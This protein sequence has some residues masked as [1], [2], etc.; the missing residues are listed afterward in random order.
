MAKVDLL[1]DKFSE[2]D[3]KALRF[4]PRRKQIT[5]NWQFILKPKSEVKDY[6]LNVPFPP[7]KRAFDE[8]FPDIRHI[9]WRNNNNH[10][11]YTYLKDVSEEE[12][13]GIENYFQSIVGCVA[14]RDCLPISFAIDFDRE[15][16]NPNL[17]Q[18]E[19]ALLRSRAKPYG[20]TKVNDSF[21]SAADELADK[22]IGFIRK[23]KFY[24]NLDAVIGMPPSDPDKEYKLTYILANRIAQELKF[25]DLSRL[26]EKK[27]KTPETKSLPIEKKLDSIK[28]SLSASNEVADRKVLLVDDLYQSGITTNYVAMLLLNAGSKQVYSLSCEKTCRNDDNTGA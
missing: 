20:T 8:V 19:I 14:I 12:I 10:T 27:F 18:T 3:I 2:E 24:N 5:G 13:S 28:G 1:Q 17:N 21:Y 23:V 11:F 9:R 7:L 16:G 26:V 25:E 4:P 6:A 22:T 15:E